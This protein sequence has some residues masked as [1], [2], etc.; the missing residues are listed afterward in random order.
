MTLNLTMRDEKPHRDAWARMH[1]ARMSLEATIR[2][3][4]RADPYQW[5]EYHALVMLS[6]A[7]ADLA[8][9][10]ANRERAA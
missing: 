2:R 5:M 3:Q 6:E 1:D 7:E 9:I 4:G 8:S 10:K